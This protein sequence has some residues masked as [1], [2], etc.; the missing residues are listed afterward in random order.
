M[1]P[2]VL[3]TNVFSTV[4]VELL[5][6]VVTRARTSLGKTGRG[7]Q[8]CFGCEC[9]NRRPFIHQMYYI[10]VSLTLAEIF[11]ALALS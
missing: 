6:V 4:A 1:Q 11:N 2:A 8:R 7:R 10:A 5:S 9:A 3:R